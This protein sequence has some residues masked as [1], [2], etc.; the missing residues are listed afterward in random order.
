MKKILS[1]CLAAAF[2]FL[3]GTAAL[4][5]EAEGWGEYNMVNDGYGYLTANFP[6]S[7]PADQVEREGTQVVSDKADAILLT[8]TEEETVAMIAAFASAKIEWQGIARM[9]IPA[10][11]EGEPVNAAE[12]F[13]SFDEAAI[14][15]TLSELAMIARSQ[16]CTLLRLTGLESFSETLAA[17]AEEMFKE[18]MADCCVIAVIGEAAEAAAEAPVADASGEMN[19]DASGEMTTEA[20][21]EMTAE[22]AA[23]AGGDAREILM[24]IGLGG[25]LRYMQVSRDGLAA[26]DTDAPPQIVVEPIEYDAPVEPGG[27]AINL[28]SDAKAG[29]ALEIVV[30]APVDIISAMLRDENGENLPVDD[31]L[32]ENMGKYLRFTYIIT[33]EEAGS[34]PMSL[35]T[36]TTT[37][38]STEAAATAVLEVN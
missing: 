38:W 16:G 32:K 17:S 8:V 36:M 33:F 28:P 7:Y 6:E 37:G 3:L 25:Y 15:E 14:A 5:S 9:G 24:A 12:V 30:T 18:V 19:A 4:A 1:L 34:V 22:A 27:Y 26:L 2:V 23:P 20:S 10:V 11:A 31:M 13:T 35:Y 29:E 21:G